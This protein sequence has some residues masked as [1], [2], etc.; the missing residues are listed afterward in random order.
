[1]H[2]SATNF[3]RRKVLKPPN[4]PAN[5]AV[6]FMPE[7]SQETSEIFLLNVKSFASE[8]LAMKR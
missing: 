2:A 4:I 3:I 1:M 5:P 7:L 6:P 8:R